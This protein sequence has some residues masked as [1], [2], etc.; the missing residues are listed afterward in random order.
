MLEYYDSF[1]K[2]ITNA[3]LG[4]RTAMRYSHVWRGH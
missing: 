4:E 1:P 2:F 3:G